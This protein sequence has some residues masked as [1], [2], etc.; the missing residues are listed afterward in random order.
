[1]DDII[2]HHGVKGQKWG[3]RKKRIVAGAAILATVAAATGAY[4]YGVKSGH[5]D[6]GEFTYQVQTALKSPIGSK[7]KKGNIG[8]RANKG[9]MFLDNNRTYLTSKISDHKKYLLDPSGTNVS[10]IKGAAMKSVA[11]RAKETLKAPS[12]QRET[13]EFA[14]FLKKN[15]DVVTKSIAEH[16]AGGAH[17]SAEDV[18]KGAKAYSDM[19]AG[20]NKAQRV[21]QLQDLFFMSTVE[22]KDSNRG[23]VAT[24]AR[25]AFWK[26][27]SDKGFSG[28]QDRVDKSIFS[29]DPIIAFNAKKSFDIVSQMTVDEARKKY[30]F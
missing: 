27:L 22:G 5:I 9:K 28:V 8:Y 29:K 7:I 18:A 16:F 24:A 4:A 25:D 17:A 21:K 20:K 13:R 3:V 1:M 12:A 10:S 30:H 6:A 11:L 26:Q 15:P 19:V 23:Q 2:E 14:K